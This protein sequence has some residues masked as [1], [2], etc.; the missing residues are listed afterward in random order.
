MYRACLLAAQLLLTFAPIALC[1]G[2]RAPP[3]REGR[4][5]ERAPGIVPETNEASKTTSALPLSARSAIDTCVE[6]ASRAREIYY[7]EIAKLRKTLLNDLEQQKVAATRKG[8][9]EEALA[10]KVQLDQ[11]G[12]IDFNLAMEAVLSESSPQIKLEQKKLVGQWKVTEVHGATMAATQY[13][14]NFQENGD[15]TSQRVGEDTVFSGRWRAE[16]LKGRFY[17]EWGNNRPST[18][19]VMKMPLSTDLTLAVSHASNETLAATKLK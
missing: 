4:V 2:Y 11:L 12:S 5:K 8:N 7:A 9:L 6:K 3:K 18:W 19:N 14:W 17:V 13:I 10:I 1:Q 15:A 16:P